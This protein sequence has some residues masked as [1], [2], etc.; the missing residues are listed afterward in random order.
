MFALFTSLG[1]GLLMFLTSSFLEY[2]EKIVPL[3]MCAKQKVF[4]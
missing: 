3:I 4:I 1:H 2:G